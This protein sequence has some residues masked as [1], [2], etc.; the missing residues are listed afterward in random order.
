MLY[1]VPVSILT[2]ALALTSTCLIF[3][4]FFLPELHAQVGLAHS[5]V[6]HELMGSPVQYYFTQS[7]DVAFVTYFEGQFRVLLREEKACSALLDL[8]NRLH[9]RLAKERAQ[10]Q[11]RLI[12]Q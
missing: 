5:F 2:F 10:S 11:G 9:D 8:N 1:A 6:C 4:L 7:H 3:F 12:H